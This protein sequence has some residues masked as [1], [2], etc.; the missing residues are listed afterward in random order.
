MAEPSLVAV[1]STTFGE[2]SPLFLLKLPSS[3]PTPPSPSLT[4]LVEDPSFSF[5]L[6]FETKAFKFAVVSVKVFSPTQQTQTPYK[7]KTP[8]HS[9]NNKTYRLPR[10][11]S[12]ASLSPSSSRR[13]DVES[14]EEDD[15]A[16]IK[17]FN[18]KSSLETLLSNLKLVWARET[19]KL[20]ISPQ[21]TSPRRRDKNLQ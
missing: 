7:I 21:A 5:F 3:F 12:N 2:P 15:I 17:K 10:Y 11:S 8:N 4:I 19:K 18:S 20:E 14:K 13:V 9:S 16:N 1:R 6:F